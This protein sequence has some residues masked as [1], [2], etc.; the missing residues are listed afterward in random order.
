MEQQDFG[1][2]STFGSGSGADAVTSGLE[3]I[4]SKSPTNWTNGNFPILFSG[5][6]SSDHILP[7]LLEQSFCQFLE[8]SQ[9]SSGSTSVRS[10]EWH[11]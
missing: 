6:K 9:K 2:M 4:W 3:V 1:F 10:F 8:R 7:R 11:C 5:S